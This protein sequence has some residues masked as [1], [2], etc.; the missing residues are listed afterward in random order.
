LVA[1]GL[2]QYV[3]Q[4]PI[5]WLLV[6]VHHRPLW[7]AHLCYTTWLLL[8]PWV[9]VVKL[10]SYSRGP[11]LLTS[12]GYIAKLPVP[13]DRRAGQVYYNDTAAAA[14]AAAG[15]AAGADLVQWQ[16]QLLPCPDLQI[17]LLPFM[18]LGVVPFTLWMVSG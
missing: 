13:V 4:P 18:V 7:W 17:D 15:A 16:Y 9:V 10:T 6:L 12:Y 5:S 11:S 1:L 3:F 14:A 2:W 8:G